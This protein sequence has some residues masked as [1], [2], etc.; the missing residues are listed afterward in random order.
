MAESDGLCTL[1][2]EQISYNC[3]YYNSDKCLSCVDLE[4]QLTEVL[5]EV[6]SLQ[7]I[8]KLLYKELNNGTLMNTFD[9][10][11]RPTAWSQVVSTSKC[12][13]NNSR[14]Y[15]AIQSSQ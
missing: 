6:N 8:N 10:W 11:T 5:L 1:S 14:S 3:E 4:S 13:Q 15:E 12:N 9:E 7:F 2:S